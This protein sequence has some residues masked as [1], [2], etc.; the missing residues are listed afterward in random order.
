MC[1]FSDEKKTKCQIYKNYKASKHK[2]IC[3]WFTCVL[4]KWNGGGGWWNLE[5]S[6][7]AFPVCS[8]EVSYKMNILEQVNLE[9]KVIETTF[10][11]LGWQMGKE[12]P[13][14]FFIC[15]PDY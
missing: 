2:W 10:S 9:I 12:M 15:S 8:I 4:H 6:F 13:E 3:A 14:D 11:L 1:W 7:P 5:L